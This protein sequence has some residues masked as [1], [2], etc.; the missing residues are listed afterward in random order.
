VGRIDQL[1]AQTGGVA[2]PVGLRS[3]WPAAAVVTARFRGPPRAAA[4]ARFLNWF[5][6][7]FVT[8]AVTNRERTAVIGIGGTRASAIVA[9]GVV[10][11]WL[12]PRL[13]R[14]MV[15]AAVVGVV[16][17][18]A[19]RRRLERLVWIRRTL[20]REAPDAV[21][22]GEFAALEPGAG[23]TF[24]TEA[25]DALASAA[26]VPLAL[27]VQSTDDRRA[28]ALLRLYEGRLHFEVV[29]RHHIGDSDVVVML[30]RPSAIAGRPALRAVR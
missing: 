10:G 4:V 11:A 20:L 27:T 5:R 17:A 21:V 7:A 3:A 8:R 25:L 14:W 26:V 19:R 18:A 23:I 29:A 24:A 15:L 13:P 9:T 6:L 2:E 1:I 28:R 22:V 12:A 30:R 16:A